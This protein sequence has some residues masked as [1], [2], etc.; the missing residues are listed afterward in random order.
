MVER[1]A[2]GDVAERGGAL[3]GGHDQIGVVG[4]VDDG[5]G[6]MDHLAADE[7]V[8]EVEQRPD[9]QPI[10]VDDLGTRGV[11]IGSR[12]LTTKPPLAPVGTITA[13]LT[14]CA[15]ISPSTSVRKSSRRSLHRN[16]PRAI[17]PPRR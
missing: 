4:V 10:A 2:V 15:F 12:R 3:V 14:I 9:E 8:G 13:F 1:H 7:V 16:P 5:V 6:R 17:G 11:G